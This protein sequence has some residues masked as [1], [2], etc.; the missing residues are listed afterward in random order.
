MSP[1]AHEAALDVTAV[2]AAASAP[3]G[4]V[5][6][7]LPAALGVIFGWAAATK[8]VRRREWR[9]SLADHHLPHVVGSVARTAVPAAEGVVAVTAILGYARFSGV[10]AAGLLVAFTASTV[11]AR[12]FADGQVPCG[13]FGGRR[14]RDWKVLVARN[15]ALL[16]LSVATLTGGSSSTKIR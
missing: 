7:L 5:R 3:T 9:R 1:P 2:V 12:R 15:L 11:R 14:S 4:G 16:G 6:R 8:L 13:C 10:L